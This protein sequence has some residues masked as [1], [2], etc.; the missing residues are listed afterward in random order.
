M[1]EPRRRIIGLD[2]RRNAPRWIVTL[3]L[4]AGRSGQRDR[5]FEAGAAGIEVQHAVEIC[6]EQA[7]ARVDIEM[8]AGAIAVRTLPRGD[9]ER[10]AR[11][12]QHEVAVA[13]D[14]A[15]QRAH[16]ATEGDI[17]QF[18]RAAAGRV[19]EGDA[20]G[21][22]EPVDRQR[23]QI[24]RPGRCRPIDA[25]L[26]VEPEIERHAVDRQFGGAHLAAH[27]RAQAEFHVELVGANLAEIVGAADHDRAQL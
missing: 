18:E 14:R 27:Q 1:I 5:A 4:L 25:S 6:Q 10:I 11:A 8:N 12:R 13:A 15:G 24:D 19:M 16:V 2:L 23:T 3:A 20:P 21:E 9:A 17:V 22:I 26:G 7:L